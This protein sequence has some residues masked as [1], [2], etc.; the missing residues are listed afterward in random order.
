MINGQQARSGGGLLLSFQFE[1]RLLQRPFCQI[2][3]PVT[4]AM[5]WGAGLECFAFSGFSI[6]IQP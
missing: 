4:Q 3:V 1:G 6:P 5:V 2:E